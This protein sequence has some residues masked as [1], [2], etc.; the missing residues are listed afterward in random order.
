MTTLAAETAAWAQEALALTEEET[1][2]LARALRPVAAFTDREQALRG[3]IALLITEHPRALAPEQAD[4]LARRLEFAAHRWTWKLRRPD[5][6]RVRAAWTALAS[7][8]TASE[9]P[10]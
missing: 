9:E 4:L 2:L 10:A 1:A 7:L 6:D 5:R 8:S 3:G